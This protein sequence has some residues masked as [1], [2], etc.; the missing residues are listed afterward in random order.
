MTHVCWFAFNKLFQHVQHSPKSETPNS[1]LLPSPGQNN[2]SPKKHCQFSEPPECHHRR[3]LP[4]TAS[5]T[6]RLSIWW[7]S[8]LSVLI[9]LPDKGVNAPQLGITWAWRMVHDQGR[10]IRGL[11]G[12]CN[13]DKPNERQ[14]DC[15]STIQI[16]SA[17]GSEIEMDSRLSTCFR[18]V[19]SG[20]QGFRH[21][22]HCTACME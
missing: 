12:T 15:N 3:R 11:A 6:R 13:A 8:F 5:S 2:Q 18:P 19:W 1:Q 10:K 14:Q 21:T 17:A 7:D 16:K 20:F 9:D 22:A 4:H